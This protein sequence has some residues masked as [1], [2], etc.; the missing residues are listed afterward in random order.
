MQIIAKQSAIFRLYKPVSSKANFKIRSNIR[1]SKEKYGN[2]DNTKME[3]K[4]G[5]RLRIK[6]SNKPKE[7][8]E[9]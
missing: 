3:T 7:Q 8:T 2:I 4:R 9:I 1:R 6:G 5:T